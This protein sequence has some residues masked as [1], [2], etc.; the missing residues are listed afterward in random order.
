V[1]YTHVKKADGGK[2]EEAG[3]KA[4]AAAAGKYGTRQGP[5]LVASK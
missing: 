4:K 1:Q 5:R 2:K 3:D